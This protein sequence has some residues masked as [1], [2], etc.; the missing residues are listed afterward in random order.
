MPSALQPGN[1][2]SDVSLLFGANDFNHLIGTAAFQNASPADQQQM[3]ATLFGT[4][5]GNYLTV[6]TELKSLAPEAHIFLPG[7]FNP[8]PSSDPTDHAFYDSVI[9]P[10]NQA[11]A[12]DAAAFGATYVDLYTPFVGN[13]LALTNI[14]I[15]DTHPNQAGYDVIAGQFDAAAVPEP[16][17]IVLLASGLAGVTGFRLR[18][19]FFRVDSK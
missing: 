3:I 7:Y 16:G 2:V 15:G 12:S 10:F 1:T 4:V 17:T 9:L 19:C 11:I 18:K 6:L 14:G 13:E 5:L 8:F